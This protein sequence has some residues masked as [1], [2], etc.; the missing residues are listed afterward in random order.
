M[1]HVALAERDGLAREPDDPLDQVGHGRPAAVLVRRPAED[2]DVA[3]VDAVEVV[4]QLVHQNAVADLEGGLHGARRDVEGLHDEGAQEQ[5]GGQ[6]DHH[7]DHRS[8]AA[9]GT[10]WEA[11]SVLGGPSATV[12]SEGSA[13]TVGAG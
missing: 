13:I 2:D 8:R 12:D 1:Q 3:P 7:H 10:A 11:V 5:G 9:S 6:G 4:A